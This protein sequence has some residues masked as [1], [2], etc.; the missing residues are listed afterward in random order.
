MR[1]KTVRHGSLFSG[2]GGFDL[3]AKWMGWENVFHCEIEPFCRKVLKYHFPQSASYEDIRKTDFKKYKGKIEVLTG[4]FPCQPYSLAGKRG[5][6]SDERHLWPAMFGAIRQIGPQWI[7]GENVF[8]IVSWN[9]GVV[10]EE[11]HTDLENEG[12]E[13]QSYVLPAAAVDAPHRRD[14]VWFVAQR[15]E[16]NTYAHVSGLQEKRP[17]QQTKGSEQHGKLDFNVADTHSDHRRKRRL[18]PERSKTTTGFAGKHDAWDCRDPWK[19]FPTES[20]ICTGNDGLPPALVRQRI[21]EDCMG[22]LSEKEI[23]KI[24]SKAFNTW[25]NETIKAAGNA[26]VP[27]VALRIFQAIQA[28]REVCKQ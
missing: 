4:G 1:R 16:T 8:G 6:K 17:K 7:V 2:I 26:I 21:R 13:V 10:F 22:Y 27:Q 12:Y 14:R 18:Y 25:R 3:A 9:E 15:V 20:P 28:I 19:N 5:G 24:I 11:V 23:D